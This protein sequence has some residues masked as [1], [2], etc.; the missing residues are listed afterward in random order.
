[1]KKGYKDYIAIA[2]AL[3]I[4]VCSHLSGGFGGLTSDA[5]SVLGVFVASLILWIFVAIDWPSL[6]TIVA[7]GM[8]PSFGFA[9]TF[10]SAFGN[11][12]V[13]F[14]I[15]TFAL[16]YPL[17]KTNFIK[18]C[19]IFF[20]TNRFASKSPWSFV[21][22]L[23]ASVTFMGLFI[24]PSVLFVAFLPFLE[25]IIEVLKL[26]K[27]GKTANM[28]M[29]GSAICINL[30]SGMTAIG[31]VWPTM[32]I[33]YYASA[34][35]VNINQFQYMAFGIPSGLI[36][37]SLLLLAFRFIYRPDDINDI[38][39]DEALKLS[40]SIPKLDKK[41]RIILLTMALTVFL[42]VG[43]SLIQNI[44]PLFY[45]TINGYTSAFPPLIGCIILFL[46][47]IDGKA[48]L[49]FK[50]VSSKGILW[51]SVL[52][53]AAATALGSGLT[54]QTIGISAWL[55]DTLA[56]IAQGLPAMAMIMF[57]VAWA[58][59]ETNFSS[60]IV[61]TTVV[62]SVA[63]TVLTALGD[64]GVAIGTLIS[65]IGFSAAVCSMTPAG[66]STV[67]TVAI[68]SGYTDTKSMFVWGFITA[69][70][71]FAVLCF[72]GYPLGSIIIP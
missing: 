33:A 1:M 23:F 49:D 10:K 35:G 28:L 45:Q 59:I 18:R 42:W 11:S 43:P 68:G 7:I 27:G 58:L 2:I 29:M 19:T 32:A 38:K 20:V 17:S 72:I 26:K 56:P 13:A 34:T 65:M 25:N 70:I 41:E 9:E 40:G 22:L 66:Q 21:C 71:A 31:H 67:N 6:L 51:G 15:F 37:I 48:I 12:T 60:N 5:V 3:I 61:T 57:F 8:I 52:M 46:V 55:S 30:S 14:L 24:S 47:K 62:S 4:I 63:L 69:V 54:N 64:S 39:A 36:I 53:T 50:E 44:F 16:V